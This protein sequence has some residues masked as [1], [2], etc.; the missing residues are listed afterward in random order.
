MRNNT[1]NDKKVKNL[2]NRKQTYK[3]R[4]NFKKILKTHVLS[5]LKITNS[6][7]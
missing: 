2:Q 4:K 1:Q 5:N 3:A 7:K 6:S